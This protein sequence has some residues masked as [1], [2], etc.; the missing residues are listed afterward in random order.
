MASGTP[1][2]ASRAGALPEVVGDDGECARLVQPGD[3]DDLTAVLG[4]LLDSPLELRS[5]GA[6]GPHACASTSSAGNPLPH[7]RSRC[8]RRRDENGVA[9][10]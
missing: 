10:C 7:R 1:I 5:L 6:S 9:A 2:V 4:E 3:V 8:T